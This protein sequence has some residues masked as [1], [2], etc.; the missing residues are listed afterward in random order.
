MPTSR[1]TPGEPG[2]READGWDRSRPQKNWWLAPESREDF[3]RAASRE[4]VRM[5]L[6]RASSKVSGSFIVGYE[7]ASPAGDEVAR[8]A[9]GY[10]SR[11]FQHCAP[12][13]LPSEDLI[14][15]CTQIDNLI[16]GKKAD[17]ARLTERAERA[18]AEVARLCAA[19]TEAL[20]AADCRKQER[21]RQRDATVLM[22]AEVTRLRAAIEHAK[23]RVVQVMHGHGIERLHEAADM[24]DRALTPP[25]GGPTT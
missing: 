25:D 5:A 6:H 1:R 17:I 9:Y 23:L 21:D 2:H 22:E 7:P 24:L 8:K 13:C 15:L 20:H 19:L 11:L 4:A 12:Q 14:T 18:E 3:T 10:L 16:A